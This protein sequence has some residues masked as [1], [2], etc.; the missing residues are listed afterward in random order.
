MYAKITLR[1]YLKTDLMSAFLLPVFL[2]SFLAAVAFIVVPFTLDIESPRDVVGLVAACSPPLFLFSV[3][4]LDTWLLV[5]RINKAI[6]EGRW[7]SGRV[8]RIVPPNSSICMIEL[9]L[10]RKRKT[11]RR[12]F[13]FPRRRC[14]RVSTGSSVA[15]AEPSLLF[16]RNPVP[17]QLLLDSPSLKELLGEG[18]CAWGDPEYRDPEFNTRPYRGEWWFSLLLGSLGVVTAVVIAPLLLWIFPAS[19]GIYYPGTA[20]FA[21]LLALAMWY[22]DCVQV[23][24]EGIWALN[25]GRGSRLVCWSEIQQVVEKS[26]IGIRHLDLLTRDARGKAWIPLYLHDLDGFLEDVLRVAPEE[27]PLHRKSKELL[28]SRRPVQRSQEG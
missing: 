16:F 3:F 6:E 23:R 15:I 21:A 19:R 28:A 24:P 13:V 9:L 22:E 1:A 25:R 7:V 5:R 2:L 10:D 12:S 27:N 20:C 17:L 11:R 18:E 14:G 26:T 4:L 8:A